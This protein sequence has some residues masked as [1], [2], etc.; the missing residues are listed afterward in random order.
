MM[1]KYGRTVSEFTRRYREENNLS[2]ADLAK[3]LKLKTP[4]YISNVERGIDPCP[5]SFCR[6]MA[7]ILP[8]DRATWLTEI[9]IEQKAQK[10]TSSFKIKKRPK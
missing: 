9:L 7:A 5:T 10:I 1:Y 3:M 8:H 6:R 4:Q 2:Q